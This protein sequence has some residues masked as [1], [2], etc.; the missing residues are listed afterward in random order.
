MTTVYATGMMWGEG[1]RVRDGALWLS[2]TQGSKLWTDA[3]GTWTPTE[4]KSVSNGLWFLP[5]GRLVGAMMHE[6]RVGVWNGQEWETYADLSHLKPGPLG[7]MLGDEHGN[8]YVDDIAY[9]LRKGEQPCPGRILF[10]GADGQTGVAAEGVH[11]PNGMTFLDGG[12]TLVVAETFEKKLKS[13]QVGDDGRLHSPEIYAD[14]AE[15]A[16]LDAGPDGIWATDEGIW[17]ATV[18]GHAVILVKDGKLVKS[19]P[20]GDGFPIA[21]C[22]DG[23]SRLLVTVAKTGGLPVAEAIGK[24]TVKADVLAFDV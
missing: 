3:S 8:L 2:D 11:F 10:V 18:A 15:L 14:I 20:T 23:N 1:P 6:Q 17:V 4:T 19:L 13:F 12:K 5:D 9:N 24:K 21:C 22:H 16:G 7:D